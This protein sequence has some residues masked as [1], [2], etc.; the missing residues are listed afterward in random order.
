[1]IARAEAAGKIPASGFGA[2]PGPSSLRGRG[3]RRRSPARASSHERTLGERTLA[4]PTEGKTR[5]DRQLG[6][7]VMVVD[8]G[9]TGRAGRSCALADDG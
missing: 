8:P 2:Y 9:V 4:L 7:G 3:D 5:E 1:M 6:P